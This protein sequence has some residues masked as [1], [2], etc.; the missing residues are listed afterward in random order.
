MLCGDVVEWTIAIFRQSFSVTILPSRVSAKSG[1]SPRSVK[2]VQNQKKL[3]RKGFAKQMSLSLQKKTEEVIDGESEDG[4][5]A[6]K[7][8]IRLLNR[9]MMF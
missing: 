2:A 8:I 3:R 4:T 6:K 1:P 7:I 9:L 5:V